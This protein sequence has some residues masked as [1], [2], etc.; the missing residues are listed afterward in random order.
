M[1]QSI[2]AST[3]F[4]RWLC[5]NVARQLDLE[6]RLDDFWEE[7]MGSKVSATLYLENYILRSIQEPLVLALN[8]VNIVFEYPNIAKDFLPLLRFWY[9]QGKLRERFAKLRSVVI[10]STEIY[11]PLN[12]KQS[13]FNVG[14]PIELPF[15]TPEQIQDLAQRHELTWFD[16]ASAQQLSDLVGGHP[17]LVRVALYHLSQDQSLS[18]EQLL[19]KAP[20]QSG[21]Y[22]DYLYRL[23]Q[24]LQQQTQLRTAIERLLASP[25]AVQMEP[26]ITYKLR[27]MGLVQMNGNTCQMSCQLYSLY[28]A[29]HQQEPVFSALEENDRVKLEQLEKENSQLKQLVN[30]DALTRIANRGYFDRHLEIEWIRL[31]RENAPLSL[32]LL[33]VD[34]FKAYNDT[35]GHQK[36]D[37]CLIK[38]A[39]AINGCL[40]R[41]EDLAARYGGEEFIIL[42]PN[43][44]AAEATK[45]AREIRLRIRELQIEHMNTLLPVKMVTASLGVAS[46]LPNPSSSAELLIQAA[47]QA[48]YLSKAEGRDRVTLSPSP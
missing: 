10:H 31:Q 19:E 22:K 13:P 32:I 7:E 40:T 47:D 17:Y 21:I 24:T 3:S 18:L 27:S 6:P 23:W 45:I 29:S 35:Y 44:P 38:I 33:D 41:N 11:V 25:K 15:F 9:E 1:K 34:C 48:L 12:L 26:A 28:F 37:Q 8:E 5:V 2:A 39:S 43:S 30:I 16:H 42:L 20:T 46:S 4:L 36:G 14:V